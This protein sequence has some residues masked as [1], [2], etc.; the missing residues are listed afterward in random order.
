MK[1]AFS[2]VE[3]SFMIL[4]ISIIVAVAVS[5]FSAIKDDAEVVRVA[6]ELSTAVTDIA[7]YYI[8]NG[9]FNDNLKEMTNAVDENGN[10]FTKKNIS[11]V[12]IALPSTS[13]S[14]FSVKI[15]GTDAVC[16]ALK[17]SSKIKNICKDN[18][19]DC[20]IKVEDLQIAW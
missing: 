1:K 11:C 13:A 8:V 16:V 3:S 12:S 17:D 9:E 15:D 2:I 10:I 5:K 4:L 7:T 18:V 19:A 14:E 20:K 6:S